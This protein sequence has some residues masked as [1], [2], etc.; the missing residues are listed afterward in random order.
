MNTCLTPLWNMLVQE[1][2]ECTG[3]ENIVDH[4]RKIIETIDNFW[5]RD[6]EKGLYLGELSIPDHIIQFKD[7]LNDSENSIND[8]AKK[9]ESVADDC[10]LCEV[11]MGCAK[12]FYERIGF[13]RTLPEELLNYF[14]SNNQ[15]FYYQS[16]YK[17][18]KEY[19]KINDTLICLK[20]FASSTPAVHSAI[21]E[22]ICTGGG[23][24]LNFNGFG[25][26]IDPGIGYVSS[27]HKQNIFIEDINAVVVTH[28]HLDHN[29]DVST[30]SA[31]LHD[32]NSYYS[33]QSRFYKEFFT[34][35]KVK[36]HEIRWLMDESTKTS[37]GNIIKGSE[38]LSGALEADIEVSENIF[39]SAILTQHIDGQRTYG[40]KFKI[41]KDGFQI[42]IGYTS[43]T[44]FFKELAQYYNDSDILIF[45]ISDIY[46]KDVQGVKQ[47]SNHLGYDGSYNLLVNG[48]PKKQLGI[49]SEF[50]CSNGDNRMLIVSSLSQEVNKKK[51]VDIIPGE[52]GMKID[53]NNKGIYCSCCKK[54]VAV[55]DLT[56]V[57]PEKEYNSIRYV[58]KKCG[59]TV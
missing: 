51:P 24:Y 1:T 4:K 45:N 3:Q 5:G 42:I 50:C 38:S 26:A 37:T 19:R 39:L 57:S 27:M 32:V 29:A 6:T 53:L 44:K 25:I 11:C 55:S 48:N 30:L 40:L 20:G 16:A 54:S 23:L 9:A 10:G 34:E 17:S 14:I 18:A 21:F 43:D 13:T 15:F 46:A 58:C 8:A 56:V 2:G 49:V 7:E 22:E 52:I 31:L 41:K 12:A 47:K 59:T 28:D 35:T 36:K 33:R